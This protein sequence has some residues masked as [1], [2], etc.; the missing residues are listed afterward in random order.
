MKQI[1]LTFLFLLTANFLLAQKE[2]T[3]EI[4]KKINSDVEK[5]IPAFKASLKEKDLNND[6]I[7]FALDTFKIENIT[8][9]KMDI[10][11]STAGM[12]LGM[13]EATDSYDKLMNKYY[14]KL[15]KLLQPA[16]KKVLIA[17]QKAWLAYRNAEN[18]LIDTMTKKEYSGGGTMQSNIAIGSFL[19]LIKGRTIAIFNYYNGVIK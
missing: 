12:N 6:E 19:A 5:L 17:A 3:K 18:N 9:Q 13:S 15:L 8:A 7:E 4:L 1:T 2:I 16:D 10:N 14:N 11:Y